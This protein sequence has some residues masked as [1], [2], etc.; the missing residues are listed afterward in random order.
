MTS[1]ENS[2]LSCSSAESESENE[3]QFYTES[4]MKEKYSP[5]NGWV[6]VPVSRMKGKTVADMCRELFGDDVDVSKCSA[7]LVSKVDLNSIEPKIKQ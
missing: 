6:A 5:E 1:S 3:Y 4:Q 7:E 2:D